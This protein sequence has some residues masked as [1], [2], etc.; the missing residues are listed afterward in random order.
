VEGLKV[1]NLPY[2]RQNMPSVGPPNDWGDFTLEKEVSILQ[3][4]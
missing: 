1:D 4:R 3:E 2:V